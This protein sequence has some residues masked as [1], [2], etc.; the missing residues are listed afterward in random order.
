L[1]WNGS[2]ISYWSKI[3]K[4]KTRIYLDPVVK[5]QERCQRKLAKDKMQLFRYE[6][7]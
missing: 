3:A 6:E 5:I 7:K 2:S 4:K 1:H